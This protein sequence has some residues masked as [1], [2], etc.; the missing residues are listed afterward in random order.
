MVSILPR[1]VFIILIALIISSAPLTFP[2][3]PLLVFKRLDS[4]SSAG[5]HN[6]QHNTQLTTPDALALGG[7]LPSGSWLAFVASGS[8]LSVDPDRILLKRIILTGHPF[9]VHKSGAVI[10]RMFYNPGI[11]LLV[12]YSRHN[13]NNL[14]SL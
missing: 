2:P 13:G 8:L 5:T 4:V 6:T 3:C 1:L 12:K 7:A 14:Y 11:A 9:K 10:K